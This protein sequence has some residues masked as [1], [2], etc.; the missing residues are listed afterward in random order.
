M[1]RKLAILL[2]IP[3]VLLYALVF[4]VPDTITYNVPKSGRHAVLSYD[5]LKGKDEQS[6][7]ARAPIPIS[8]EVAGFRVKQVEI[9]FRILVRSIGRFDNAFQTASANDGIR[10]ELSPPAKMALVVRARGGMQLK[11]R[12]FHLTQSFL[13]N[14]WYSVRIL[15]DRDNRMRAW[16]DDV[17]VLDIKDVRWKYDL[18]DIAVGTGF[19]RTRPFDGEIADFTIAY[20]VWGRNTFVGLTLDLLRPVLL[21]VACVL[22]FMGLWLFE[23][24]RHRSL[25]AFAQRACAFS[26][27]FA[28]M[29]VL[30]LH[31]FLCSAGLLKLLR[32]A[33]VR[34]GLHLTSDPSVSFNNWA[35]RFAFPE[36]PFEMATYLAVVPC[37]FLYYAFAYVAIYRAGFASLGRFTAAIER[38][39][40]AAA[41]YFA[42]LFLGNVV[43]ILYQRLFGPD[44]PLTPQ[45]ILWLCIVAL[46]FYAVPKGPSRVAPPH[47]EA[48]GENEMVMEHRT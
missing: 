7:D 29:N 15:V 41:I 46:P 14:E 6:G 8:G 19:S 33:G 4:L 31:F 3:I 10:M 47:M 21:A 1:S 32:Q 23:V 17:L 24:P 5:S 11:P 48:T 30:T 44:S 43:V 40:L 28:R 42:A 35:V 38:R 9:S 25:V 16:L 37:L 2:I 36:K 12:G 26:G 39:R 18:S 45:L 20:T 34:V 27:N 13:L 22:V